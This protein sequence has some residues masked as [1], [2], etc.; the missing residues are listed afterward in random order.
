MGSVNIFLT[1]KAFLPEAFAYEN[2]L[3]SKGW[4]VNIVK[5]NE[6]FE[7]CDI[8]ICFNNF[9]NRLIKQ[10]SKSVIHEYHSLSTG[11]FCRA[12]N[13]VK[14]FLPWKP[15]GRIFL[16]EKVR[17]GYYFI[18][19]V[20]Y[21][22]REM[23]VDQGFFSERS[24]V[25]KYDAIY[26]GSIKGRSNVVEHLIRLA[27]L[28]WK[29]VVV[30]EPTPEL[31]FRAETLSGIVLY[32]NAPRDKLYKLYSQCRFG[33]NLTP[34]EYPLNIQTSTK[35]LEY[36][37]AGL[38]VVSNRYEWINRFAKEKNIPVQWLGDIKKSPDFYQTVDSSDEIRDLEWNNLLTNAKFADFLMEALTGHK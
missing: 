15:Q 30:G 5:P 25:K 22:N 32:G 37:A 9:G 20:P 27:K 17:K 36:I 34:D 13:F 10:K 26:C 38:G 16:N 1:G 7:N 6:A 33:L 35:V 19:S 18:D 8:S 3:I 29:I 24:I 12:K 21:L 2:F 14:S 31:V 11:K 23:G 4:K 28:N